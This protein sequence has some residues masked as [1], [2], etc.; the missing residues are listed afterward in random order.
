MMLTHWRGMA[1]GLLLAVLA[2]KAWWF[3]RQ[4]NALSQ[5]N[6]TLSQQLQTDDTE[7]KQQ[8]A[9]IA[10]NAAID[11]QYTEELARA[12]SEINHL[13][14]DVESGRRRLRIAATC[15]Q[16]DTSASVVDDATSPRLT[17]TAERD[18]FTLRERI[19]LAGKQ[20]AGLQGY[21]SKVCLAKG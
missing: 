4:V 12:K 3:A 21:V 10:A 2:G 14:V 18:Y 17:E 15:T 11:R 16:R 7:L 19:A 9:A 8:R 1:V 20:I 13:R 6:S 5:E